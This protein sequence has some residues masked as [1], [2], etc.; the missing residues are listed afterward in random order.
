MRL[1]LPRGE[2]LEPDGLGGFASG[3]VALARTRRYHALLLAAKAPPADRVVLVNG[4]DAGLTT[5]AGTFALSSQRYAPSVTHPDGADSIT[6]FT[7]EPWPTW[8]FSLPD[9]T[10]VVHEVF[11]PPGAPRIALSWRLEADPAAAPS[12]G[13]DAATLEVRPLLS[14][15]DFHALAHENAACRMDAEPVAG[16]RAS[17]ACVR[18]RPYRDQPAITMLANAAFE[19]APAWYRQFEYDEEKARGL[20]AIEDLAA[21]GV[22][23]FDLA[24]GPAVLVLAAF[25][26]TL[27][28]TEK[29]RGAVA[30]RE[31]WA[32][33][34]TAR[35]GALGPLERSADAYLVRRGKGK[36]I[37]AG[38]PWFGDWGRD[39]FIALRGLCLATGRIADARAI[40]VE[41]AGA[42]SEGMLPNRFP[43]GGETPEYN[44]VDASL[45][46]VIAVHETLA[47]ALA[48]GSPV[49]AAERRRMEAAVDAILASYAKGTRYGIHANGDGLL[50]AGEPGVQLTWMD[51]R[52][53]GRVIT[54]RIGKPVEIQALW[55]NALGQTMARDPRWRDL[56]ERGRA[57]F[58]R[59]FW[60]DELG[61]LYDVVDVDGVL[62]ANDARLRPNQ[63]FAVGGLPLRLLE[64]P[65]A[66]AVVDVIEAR[67]LTPRALRTLAP[68]EPGY[69]PHYE[70]GPAERDAEYHQGTAWPWLM[71][72][73][74]DAWLATRTPAASSTAARVAR[75]RFLAPLVAHLES[76]GLGHVS[77][78]EDAEPD[79]TPR[80]CPFQAW[81]VGE[82]IR[83]TQLVERADAPH[84]AKAAP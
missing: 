15:R 5:P 32:A 28:A 27:T 73:F 29:K 79:F 17:D 9:G 75:E 70:G 65:R 67:L 60:S 20:D 1:E 8:T 76:A 56:Y 55:L 6:A 40:L 78:I 45:W 34:E 82:L 84:E 13:L 66:R 10:R 54:P 47:A 37:I 77:E 74:V 38:Y 71:A 81:S 14:V 12:A 68:G 49:P 72:A 83:L 39:T 16:A 22:F 41:W 48:T 42:V 44:A 53:D 25:D 19:S 80:G 59:K 50:S 4:L 21:P 11:V 35:R 33:K 7:R 3:T 18:F 31:A 61:W 63:V 51:A 64:G 24:R 26:D 36:T 2:W 62:G 43:D 58:E 23:R 57:S 46:Y 69:A 52:V 30:T